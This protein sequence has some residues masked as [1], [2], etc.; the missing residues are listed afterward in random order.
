[1]ALATKLDIQD[2]CGADQ[3]CAGIKAGV[4]A[5]IH[6]MK[7]LFEAKE[8]EGLL[9]VDAANAFNALSRPA[10]LWNCRVL[11][12][13][14]SRFLFNSY[15]GYAAIILKCYENGGSRP[16]RKIMV[17]YSKEGTT[18]GCPLAMLEYACAVRP[19]ITRLK[20]PSKHKQVWYADDSSCAAQLIR[21]REWLLL[22]LEIG[23]SYGYFAEPS[24]SVLVVKEPLF[25]IAQRMFQDLQVSVVLAS[26]FLGGYVGRNAEVHDY[27]KVKVEGWVKSV[28]CLAKA[29]HRYPQSAYAAFTH[30]LSCE[31]THLQRVITGCDEDYVPLRDAIQKMFTPAV[32]GREILS[33]EHDLFAL[34]A[35]QGGL[36]IADPVKSANASYTVS[37]AATSVL[38]QA[39][40]AGESATWPRRR[41]CN[42]DGRLIVCSMRCRL[43]HSAHCVASSKER[44]LAGLL[45]CH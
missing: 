19:L 17:I 43:H 45:C 12:P 10:A 29:A 21:I 26:R 3:L 30:S 24:K 33:R 37:K 40:I 8:T 5:A 14:C 13:R 36:A 38:Q 6:A 9:L 31:W 34:P 25:E 35:K 28:D 1:M 22:L 16:G 23:P 41:T 7:E 20:D 27:V 15:R 39:I 44:H 4:E 11:W 42:K 32:L 18:Q 2:V